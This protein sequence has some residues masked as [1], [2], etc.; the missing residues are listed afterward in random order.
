MQTIATDG[1]VWSVISANTA[2]PI[3]MPFG[4]RLAWIQGTVYQMGARIP[5][6]RGRRSTLERRVPDTPCMINKPVQS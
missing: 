6:G 4:G 1:Q 5:T 3:V 2:E